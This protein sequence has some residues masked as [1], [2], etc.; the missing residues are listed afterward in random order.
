MAEGYSLYSELS[1]RHYWKGIIFL[2]R[3]QSV[4]PFSKGKI[5]VG[6]AL[7]SVIFDYMGWREV[8]EILFPYVENQ[9]SFYLR[10][11]SKF[12]HM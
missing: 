1:G 2:G 8:I 10:M 6:F 5:P 3:P 7:N 9:H 11:E 4:F 12:L